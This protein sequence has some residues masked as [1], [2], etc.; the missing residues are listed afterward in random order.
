MTNRRRVVLGAAALAVVL[1]VAPTVALAKNTVIGTVNG[2]RR[3]W[4]R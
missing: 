3:K 1:V 4:S 2:K